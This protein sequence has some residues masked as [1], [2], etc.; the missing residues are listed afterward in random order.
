MQLHMQLHDNKYNAYGGFVSE[1]S[2]QGSNFEF[3][4]SFYTESSGEY[5]RNGHDKSKE[6]K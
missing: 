6:A 2:C 5:V 4:G 1:V 3:K